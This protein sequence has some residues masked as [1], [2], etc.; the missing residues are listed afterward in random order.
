M[1]LYHQQ[2]ASQ[3]VFSIHECCIHIEIFEILLSAKDILFI[4]N[5]HKKE[6]NNIIFLKDLT[7]L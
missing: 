1:E 7:I 5:I 2:K 3:F 4:Q 6:N